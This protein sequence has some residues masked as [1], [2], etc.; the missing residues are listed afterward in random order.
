[1]FPNLFPADGRAAAAPTCEHWRFDLARLGPVGRDGLAL[2]LHCRDTRKDLDLTYALALEGA[3]LI[4]FGYR[5]GFLVLRF[6]GTDPGVTF[7][8]Q[9]TALAHL[10]PIPPLYRGFEMAP[11]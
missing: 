11:L 8:D 10:P 9:M 1:L 6:R 3:D 5:V 7:F 2:T 4:L